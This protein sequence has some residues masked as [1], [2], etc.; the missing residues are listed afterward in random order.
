MTD[1]RLGDVQRGPMRPGHQLNAAALESWLAQRGLLHGPLQLEQFQGGQSNPTYLLHSGERRYVLRKQP[2]GKV[3]PS[4]HRIDREYRVISALAAHSAVPVPQLRGYEQDPALLGTPF[5]LMDYVPGRLFNAPQ[6]PAVAAPQRRELYLSKVRTLATLHR[7]SP[8]AAG[9]ED[10]G[11]TGGYL[12]RQLQRW[13]QQY[14]RDSAG[15]LPDLDALIVWLESHLPEDE[16]TTVVHGDFR[17]GNL[18]FDVEGTEV[19]AVL[20][21][22]LATLGHPLADL[23]YCLLPYHLPTGVDGVRGLV[24]ED[25]DALVLPK[26]TELLECYCLHVSRNEIPNWNYH[27]AFALFRTAAILQGVYQRALAGNAADDNARSVGLRAG[28]MASWGWQIA[29]RK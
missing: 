27:L 5:Y 12:R 8:A 20:D 18:L 21:W 29:Q 26:E 17:F 22:E 4:A 13:G 15:A 16:V 24:G 23:A 14:R 11:P 7:V 2:P 28:L 10:F 1:P 3:L 25:L 6:L 9:L 19:R